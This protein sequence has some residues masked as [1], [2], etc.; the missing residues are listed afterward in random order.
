MLDVAD[1]ISPDI[2]SPKSVA[3]MLD[4]ADVI[5]PDIP[6]P[7]HYQ[8]HEKQFD[9]IIA[10]RDNCVCHTPPGDTSVSDVT[11]TL[12]TVIAEIHRTLG[13]DSLT[14]KQRASWQGERITRA[15]KSFMQYS[16]DNNNDDDDGDD[17]I[18]FDRHPRAST[19]STSDIFNEIQSE[20]PFTRHDTTIHGRY[21]SIASVH[22][23]YDRYIHSL[24]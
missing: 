8:M 5:S 18:M 2:T 3:S 15:S 4:V 22:G 14:N 9:D 11:H 23:R 19:P 24:V 21:D 1:V 10:S 17:D 16:L 6:S 12:Y 7:K 13:D 20:P